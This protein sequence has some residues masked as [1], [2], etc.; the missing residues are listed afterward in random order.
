MLNRYPWQ[1]AARLLTTTLL[2]PACDRDRDRDRDDE[3]RR[4]RRRKRRRRPRP[5]TVRLG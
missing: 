5:D 3:R 1:L 4:R 2:A